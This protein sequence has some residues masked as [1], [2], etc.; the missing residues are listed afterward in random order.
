MVV[1]LLLVAVASFLLAGVSTEAA[2]RRAVKPAR[3]D[4]TRIVAA[5]P[6]GGYR[7]GNPAA[8]VKLVEYGSISCP[9]CA[10]FADESA[11]LRGVYVKSG[12]V[13]FEYRPYLLFPTDPGIFM[14]LRCQGAA[15]FFGAIDKLYADQAVWEARLR[16]LPPERIAQIQAMT[17]KA[18]I[19][20]LVKVTGVDAYFRQRGMA[21]ARIQACLADDR[22]LDALVAITE[23]GSRQGVDSTP[24]LYING[25][26]TGAG[27]WAALEPLLK[28][29]GG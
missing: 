26:P 24:T 5:T 23:R 28:S 14:L 1:R 3:T 9:H 10:R 27:T 25:Q 8:A 2:P 6:E 29:S 20:A 15:G 21:P 7:M 4:W 12:R 13:S 16:A 22:N 17:P 19:A 18:R 11:G